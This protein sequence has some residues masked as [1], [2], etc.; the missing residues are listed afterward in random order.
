[1]ITNDL[2]YRLTNCTLNC[3]LTGDAVIKIL[4][5]DSRFIDVLSITVIDEHGRSY[6]RSIC[7]RFHNFLSIDTHKIT[8]YEE[9]RSPA[10][11]SLA[12]RMF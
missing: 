9:R 6:N 3:T 2:S 7:S 1:M 10:A 8:S 4:L 11:H 12:T 5:Q